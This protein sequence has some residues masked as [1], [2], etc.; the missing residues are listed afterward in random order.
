MRNAIGKARDVAERAKN[1]IIIGVDTIGVLRGKIL[2]KPKNRREAERMLRKV[3]GNTHRV[4]TGLC[5][6]N[7]F[8]KKNR[9]AVVTTRVTFR[10]VTPRE[11]KD[12][13]DSGEW[14]G[15]AGAYAIQ[16]RAKKFV[17]KI[18]GDVTN[19]VGVPIS[20][21]KKILRKIQNKK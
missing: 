16:G 14:K 5:V 4:I 6:M 21:L 11:F 2:G 3:F 7:L 13:L 9:T 18:E 12:Y 10:K 8:H 1:A 17:E 15:K 19:V 20:A